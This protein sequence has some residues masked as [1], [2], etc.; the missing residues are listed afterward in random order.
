MAVTADKINNME[1]RTEGMINCPGL[2][3]FNALARPKARKRPTAGKII[4]TYCLLS[5]VCI[6]NYHMSQ[7]EIILP[8]LILFIIRIQTSCS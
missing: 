8:W 1:C 5:M 2:I 6:S 3:K 4:K 7:G